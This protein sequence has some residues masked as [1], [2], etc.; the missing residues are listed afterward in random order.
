MLLTQKFVAEQTAVKFWNQKHTQHTN[1]K[2]LVTQQALQQHK[3]NSDYSV[4]QSW[5]CNPLE[6]NRFLLQ[7]KMQSLCFTG[8]HTLD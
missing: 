1:L 2:H 3:S 5:F 4:K 8:N 7:E 6:M